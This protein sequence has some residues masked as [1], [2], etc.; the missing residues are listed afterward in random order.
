MRKTLLLLLFT[1]YYSIFTYAQTPK[2]Y[3]SSEI[4]L[5]L[6]KLDVLGSV[7]YIA[8]HP[9]DENTR[10]L[11]Y[12]A[13]EKLYRTGY[14]SLTRGDGGQNLIGDEQ[15]VDLGLIRTQEL[16]AARRIDG[17]EQFFSRAYD[18]G[19]CKSSDE[20]LKTWGHDKIL[21]DVVW[22][23][24]KFKP[25]V[26]I[27]RFPPDTRAGH[28][29]HAA[30]AILAREAFDAAAD[31]A[32]FPEQLK[33][34]V[35]VWQAKR[36][37]WNTYN[38]GNNNTQSEDQ[39]KLDCGIYNPLLGKSYG[40]IAAVSRSQHKSQGF[41]V[42]AQR[43][44]SLEYFSTTAGDKPVNDLLDGI[45]TAWSRTTV[46]DAPEIAVDTVEKAV[47]NIITDFSAEHPERSTP[48]LVRLYKLLLQT[49]NDYWREQKLAAIKNLIV[50]CSG[51]FLEATTSTQ[52]AV[53]GDSLKINFSLND[54]LGVTIQN[55]NASFK[56][57]TYSFDSIKN[58]LASTINKTIFIKT[59]EKPT[60]P[61]WLV[62]PM[63]KGSFNV[64]DQQLIGKAENDP[65]SATFDMK[66]E[67]TEF[68]FDVPVKY[69]YT[70]PVKGELYQ[71]IYITPDLIVNV[72]PSL[73]ITFPN[74]KRKSNEPVCTYKL[75]T[76][77]KNIIAHDICCGDLSGLKKGETFV[78]NNT[79][80]DYD[81]T[82]V[83]E[84]FK[85]GI[86][87]DTL[88]RALQEAML[89]LHEINY[90]HIPSIKYYSVA[91][92]RYL[93]VDLKVVGKTI[94]Y[95]P[96]AGDKVPQALE[97]MGY[98]VTILKQAD[99]TGVNLK[100]FD[101]VVT[102]VRAYNV[103][104]WMS[105]VYDT[106]MQYV[107][108][109]GVFLVQYNV[110]NGLSSL[111]TKIGPYPFTVVNKRVTDET[112]KVNLLLPSDAALNY[113]NKITGKDFDGW[114]QERSIYDVENID[115]SYKRIISMKD[116]G[117]EEQDGSLLIADYGKGKFVYT[118]LVFF[119][120]LP[121]GVPGA[122]RLF[123]NLLAKPKAK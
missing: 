25:D 26:I 104:E 114:I 31:P 18:F 97:Q 96:G 2:T 69:K 43:G 15:G 92:K 84:E 98:R 116:P 106:L 113:P 36:L 13:N 19:F 119:R 117:E 103:N 79:V 89:S 38:F 57:V 24:R 45:N 28:G 60:Q 110:N 108:D 120:E 23:I 85:K 55:A 12:L 10:L 99:I 123:A 54:R 112:A 82:K 50:Q 90:D 11:A 51:L 32:K 20:A 14:L 40:E 39:F 122:Y 41:G 66:I 44:A 7:L 30:S 109:G 107:K 83:S 95:I 29:H 88:Y 3:T 105:N 16:L 4:L 34:G 65:I 42:P 49:P 111:K 100:Q 81:A 21:S 115:S 101:A 48:A 73:V 67:G 59:D 22:V 56:G 64:S 58:D 93:V 63:E 5:Q 94:G 70:D 118:G 68:E 91:R 52:Y 71:P 27:T 1:V 78:R 17:A 33:Q 35:T 61:Y 80:F 62:D 8:A 74:D 76:D 102:G 86:Q 121:A 53:Q 9:D 72:Q 77:G 87:N 6:K 47:K 75:M 37:L 46:N